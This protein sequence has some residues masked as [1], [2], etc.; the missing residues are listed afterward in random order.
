MSAGNPPAGPAAGEELFGYQGDFAAVRIDWLT[1]EA[2][3]RME[4]ASV[5]SR[6][7]SRLFASFVEMT[8]NIIQYGEPSRAADGPR[9]AGAIA[10]GRAPEGY[11]VS[12][13]NPVGEVHAA[14]LRERLGWIQ[15]MS[16]EEIRAAY[17]QRLA[18]GLGRST[19]PHSRGAGLGLLSIARTAGGAVWFRLDPPPAAGAPHAF[20]LR[21][22]VRTVGALP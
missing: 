16:L 14:R 1:G 21:A 4:L 22:V 10:F 11:W 7:R 9:R 20:S 18:Q 19:D 5:A 2:R 8:Q 15:A 13:H 12:S 3:R 6:A 17:Q